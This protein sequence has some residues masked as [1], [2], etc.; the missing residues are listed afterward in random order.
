[1]GSG[2]PSERCVRV[3]T[4]R[5]RLSVAVEADHG[6][7]VAQRGRRLADGTGAYQHDGGHRSQQLADAAVG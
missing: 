5:D 1:M 3:C 4:H 6:P 2:R 7:C